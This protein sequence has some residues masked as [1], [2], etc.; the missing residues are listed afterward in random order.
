M[1]HTPA[2]HRTRRSATH[3]GIAGALAASL[4]AGMLSTVAL[5]AATP[6]V[7]SATTTAVAASWSST[8]NTTGFVTATPPAGTVS[9]TVTLSGGGG[10]GGGSNNSSSSGGAGGKVS[11]T[12]A[13]THT[14]GE[15]AVQ[16]GGG[17][18]GGNNCNSS[19]SSCTAGGSTGG[20]GYEAGGNGGQSSSESASVQGAASGGAG[21]GA[22]GLFLGTGSSGTLV[23]VGGGGGGGGGSHGCDGNSSAGGTGGAGESG[24]SGASSAGAGGGT[25]GDSQGGGS[26]G[27]AGGTPAAGSASSAHNG[28]NEG[29]TSAGGGGAGAGGGGGNGSQDYCTT[30]NDSAGGGGGGGSVAKSPYDTSVTYAAG[31]AGGGTSGA[32]TAGSITLT[33]NVDQLSV[34]NPGNQSNVSGSA[35][36]S[37]TIAAPHDTTGGNSVTFAASGLPAGLSINP[38]SGAVTGTPTAACACSVT[39]T[40]TD[41]EALSASTSFTWNVTNTVSVANPGSQSSTTGSA[42]S[43]LAASATDSQSGATLTWSATGL[44]AGLSINSSTGT[45]TGTPTTAGTSSV[46]IKATDGSGYS[47]TASFTWTT[48]NTVSV[49][50]PGSQSSIT[51]S[52]ISAVTNSATDS[53]SGATLTWSAT[54]LPAGLSIN[55]STGTITGT[56]TTAGTSSVTI[57]AADGSGFSGSTAFTWTTS[58]TVAVTNPGNQSDVSGTPITTVAAGAS[59]TSSTTTLTYSATG[60]PAGLSINSSTG[61]IT[62]TPTTAGTPA[63]TVT[64]TDGSGY[65]ASASFTWTVTNVVALPATGSQS[66]VSGTP[67]APLGL[68]ATDTSSTATVVYSATDLPPGLSIDSSTG[69]ISGTPTVASTYAVSVTAGD[70][71]GFSA[72]ISFSWTVTNTLTMTD[73]GDQS[74]TSGAAIAPLAVPTSDSVTDAVLSFTDSGTLPPGL[75]VDPSAGT[76]SGAPTTAGT[77]EVTITATDNSGFSAEVSFSWTVTNMVTVANPGAQS[78]V[79]GAT[80]TPFTVGADDSSSTAILAFGATG[81]PPGVSIDPSTGT[82]SGAPTTAGS[83]AVTVT[84]SDG[85]GFSGTTSFSWTVTNTVT[86]VNP[87]NQSGASG[88]AVT[89]VDVTATDSSS[90]A[91]LTYAATGLPSGLSIDPT[92]GVISGTPAIGGTYPV[93][94]TATDGA[95]SSDSATFTWSVGDTVTVTGPG[96]QTSRVGISIIPVTESATDTSSVAGLTWSA[97][98]LPPGLSVSPTTGTIS[99]ATLHSGIYG[100]TVTVTDSAGFQASTGFTWTTVGAAVSSVTKVSGPGAGGEKV[101]IAGTDFTEVSSVTFGSVPAAS[102]TVNKG[103]TK[104]T[105]YTPVEAAGTVDVIVTT[106]QGP[107]LP[108]TGA[109]YTFLGPVVTALS[110]HSTLITGGTKVVITG[111]DFQGTTAVHFGSVDATSFTVNKAGTKITTYSPA[112]PAGQVDVTVTTP[113]G[114]SPTSSADQYIFS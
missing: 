29:T 58:N 56:P 21:G 71:S 78:G 107:S 47:G 22:T 85:A 54:G 17:G 111:T 98:G 26:G 33:W 39:V 23:A 36:S 27:T 90:T 66:D 72:T 67:I 75:T 97:T 34:T 38:S 15:V 60:L 44:P 103:G 37:L 7:A 14:T 3:S 13:L 80:I 48:S 95:L 43:G 4:V 112:E 41:S 2:T 92:T 79:S 114:T 81:L 108:S 64:A 94:V 87:G 42:I 49:A 86:V 106:P 109:Q 5:V 96:D 40:A 62:G 50:N 100:V 10:G 91:T 70:G 105:A 83:Y 1:D 6:G 45:I 46:T 18:G 8:P 32:G 16:L 63:V 57:K 25:S 110:R 93:T 69:T 104:I 77:Y 65:S 30:G 11:G 28:G 76:I 89:P 55:S 9:A 53:Q 35:V 52:A 31:S 102:F 12:F 19:L 84:A 82:V 51:G 101:I 113:G 88:T 24:G 73:P 20:S 74:S 61:T 59:D 99:G 68:A